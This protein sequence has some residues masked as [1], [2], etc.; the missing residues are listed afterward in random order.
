[1]PGNTVKINN[2]EELEWYIG[3][4]RIDEV[5]KFLEGVGTKTRGERKCRLCGKKTALDDMGDV[6]SECYEKS[7]KQKPERVYLFNKKR[8]VQIIE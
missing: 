3:D 5:I 2:T 8:D 1:M 4:S 6:C 7:K